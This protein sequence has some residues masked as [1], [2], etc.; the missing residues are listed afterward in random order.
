METTKAMISLQKSIV[1]LANQVRKTARD[2]MRVFYIPKNYFFHF[3]R[4]IITRSTWMAA[5]ANQV[6]KTARDPM[7]VFYIPKNYFFQFLRWIITRSTWMA[8]RLPG[9]YLDSTINFNRGSFYLDKNLPEEAWKYLSLC[10]KSSTNPHHIFIA[11]VCLMVGLGRFRDALAAFTRVNAL[12]RK[13]ASALGIADSHIRFLEPIWVGA[14]GHL[15]QMNYLIKLGLLEGRGQTDTI[16]Y[17]PPNSTI[18]NRFLFDMYRPYLTVVEREADLPMPLEALQSLTFD[19]LAP[20]LPNGLTVHVW[21]IAANT[22]RRWAA[23]GRKPV[24]SF[25]SALAE[26]ARSAL[27]TVG[28]PHN[29]WFVALHVRE[30]TSNLYHS[31]LHNVL[32][33]KIE[34]YL[35]T[36][37]EITKR[38]GWVI[39]MGD[40]TMKPLPAVKN[41]F[42]Y[43]HSTLRSDWMDIF[44]FAHARFF[45]GTSSG[46]AYVPSIF[47]AP[48]VLTNWWPPAQRPWHAHDIFMPKLYRKRS[49]GRY[50]SLSASLAE[51][52]GY[53][54]S[55]DYLTR[56]E[57]VILEDTGTE[58]IRAA[59]V[60]MI[61]RI[62][63]TVCY[64]S[65]DLEWRERVEQIYNSNSAYGSALI[66]RDFL[67]NHEAILS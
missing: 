30:R 28:I 59:V 17:L 37:E 65:A 54:N 32:N 50:L 3:L 23:E 25:P 40:P 2:P 9:H 39:R 22:Y 13:K 21:E 55:I 53:C 15:A 36:I 52:F 43:C 33:A 5:L 1:F 10:L 47:G 58:D 24:L 49:T 7:R 19:F 35:P 46:P 16:I 20:Q 64:D 56:I 34:D 38:G 31:E 27:A 11:A 12:R 61:E 29:A 18:A 8:A 44:L 63:G 51:P 57:D 48:S 62:D 26:R 14:F 41:F 4:W 60:E 6:R 67:R 66:A 45:I 42:D